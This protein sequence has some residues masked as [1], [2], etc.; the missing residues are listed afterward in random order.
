VSTKA[1]WEALM[2]CYRRLKIESRA[3]FCAPALADRGSD[4]LIRF[5]E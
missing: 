3:F 4:L 2:S 1:F 5:G